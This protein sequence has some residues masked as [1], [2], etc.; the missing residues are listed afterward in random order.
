M[1]SFSV[2]LKL[3]DSIT[4]N[5]N[6]AASSVSKVEGGSKQTNKELA[7]LGKQFEKIG[8]AAERAAI[9]Q[10]KAF[11]D[12]WAKIGNAAEKA[13]LQQNKALER[14]VRRDMAAVDRME[15][16]LRSKSF[17]GGFKEGIGFDKLLSA[18]FFGSLLAE[19]VFKIADS[20]VEGARK[21][22]EVFADGVKEA[23]KASSEEETLRIG[24]TNTLGAAG[25]KEFREN[26]GKFDRLAP[27]DDSEIRRMML[28]MRR[29]GMS[30][31][32]SRQAFAT[33][34]DI[35][36]GDAGA[37][38]GVLEQFKRIY[39]KQG[40]GK[41]QLVELLGNVGTTI[42]DF[43]KAL[44]AKMH[45]SAKAAEK[46]AEE[47][48]LDPQ[49]L[50]NMITEAQNKRQGGIAGSG[51]LKYAQS[52]AGEWKKISDLP[53]EYYKQ[54]VDSPG[55]HRAVE[56][57]GGLLAHLNPDSEQ[58]RRIMGSVE[59]MFDQITSWIGDPDATASALADNLESAI[60][61]GKELID[62]FKSLADS[63]LPTL[64]T[65]QDI[66]IAMRKAKAYTV[67]TDKD[68]IDVGEAEADLAQKRKNRWVEQ[69]IRGGH[70]ALLDQNMKTATTQA[71]L[72]Q[73]ISGEFG[74]VN[75]NAVKRAAAKKT[76]DQE[77]SIRKGAG[78][79]VI[80]HV[81]NDI[82]VHAA[83]GEETNETHE[84][85]GREVGKVIT[86]HAK[87]AAAALGG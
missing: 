55:Y 30:Q 37:V 73:A 38:G 82:T 34:V 54:L 60:D 81:Q 87:R 52:L 75:I 72:D 10:Q 4:S 27:F 9:K 86:S 16:K 84:R 28:Q 8:F 53:G 14:S 47:G 13:R 19:G 71:E 45:I 77:N 40:I 68:V 83:P 69:S 70:A 15:E 66:V 33:A 18:S 6:R 50:M 67:G 65:L 78:S 25:G 29:A 5:A 20:F 79:N 26:I 2:E 63:L 61:F 48:G 3:V 76:E 11:A 42:P 22:V 7:A 32:A 58:G 1:E 59:H 36:G 23:F 24:E 12:S 51:G 43:Y 74:P 41:R 17:G 46:K 64:D 56:A 80:M 31:A 35:G 39:T 85:A 21:A 57:L 44:G 62:T 49:L